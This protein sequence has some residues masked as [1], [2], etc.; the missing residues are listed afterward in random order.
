MISKK[1]KYDCGNP[2]KG[3]LKKIVWKKAKE[4]WPCAY[5]IIRNFNFNNKMIA[6]VSSRVDSDKISYE[7]AAIE[8]VKNN[9]KIW[10]KWIPKACEK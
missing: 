6:K 7:E 5:E 3:W 10:N 8:W 4:K 9:K 1:W 2:K